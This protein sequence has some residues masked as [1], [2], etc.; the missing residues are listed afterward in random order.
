MSKSTI[1]NVIVPLVAVLL[2]FFF[3]GIFIVAIGQNP[4]I[5]YGKMFAGT[6]GSFYGFGQVLF[7]TTPLIFTGLSVALAF[8][9]GLFNIGA[10]GQAY[11]AAFIVG[12]VAA[13]FPGLTPF[14]SIPL[15]ILIGF[16]AG[17]LYGGIPGI[18]KAKYGA[19]E[20]ITT[21]MLNFISFALVSYFMLAKFAV[22]ATIHTEE[23]H[24]DTVIPR[25]QSLFSN[26]RGSPANFT[27][28]LALVA[29][30][31]IKYLLENT[32]IGYNIRS[33]GLNPTAAEYGGIS[34]G[35]QFFYSMFISGGLAGLVGINYVLGYKYYFEEGFSGGVG[36]MGIAVA[37]LA[38]NNPLGVLAS[39][40]LFGFLSSGGL[41]INSMVPK[42]L[43]EILKAIIIVFLII[44]TRTFNLYLDRRR[45][46][47]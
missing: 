18:L 15:M 9:A 14:V 38:K 13:Y 30:F 42:E 33:V 45:K 47:G 3:G 5:V 41:L 1:Q 4:F 6:F 11:F 35:K 43:V 28:V 7:N 40:L 36:F 8:K 10:E 32:K 24:P 34:I 31:A 27:V 19:H 2:S 46:N 20:V 23:I 39:A 22:T 26:F 17:G 25:L 16:I 37:L 21:I 29:I 12:I 44:S